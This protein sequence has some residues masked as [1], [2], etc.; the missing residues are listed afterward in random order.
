MFTFD[1]L[2]IYA[3]KGTNRQKKLRQKG[4]KT[5][6]KREINKMNVSTEEYKMNTKVQK[7]EIKKG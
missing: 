2:L 6:G 5:R 7:S 1:I 4:I 3:F